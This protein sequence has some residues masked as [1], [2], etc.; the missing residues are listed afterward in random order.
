M[1]GVHYLRTRPRPCPPKASGGAFIRLVSAWVSPIGVFARRIETTAGYRTDAKRI[2]LEIEDCSLVT[3]E[4]RKV[5]NELIEKSSGQAITQKP[6]K[7]KSAPPRWQRI[8][9][10]LFALKKTAR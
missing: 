8:L 4:A 6:K 9:V 10:F 1:R 7:T 5:C 2:F 3:A